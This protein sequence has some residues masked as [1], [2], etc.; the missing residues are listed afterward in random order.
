MNL[1]NVYNLEFVCFEN[2]L[3]L[4]LPCLFCHWMETLL[5]PTPP[6]RLPPSGGISSPR[7]PFPSVPLCGYSSPH[8]RSP[9]G[10]PWGCPPS[11][12]GLSCLPREGM[13]TCS[14]PANGFRMNCLRNK[15]KKNW[16]RREEKEEV[17]EETR[18]SY[19]LV[20]SQSCFLHKVFLLRI[21]I[22]HSCS[23]L[24]L[25]LPLPLPFEILVIFQHRGQVSFCG[26][27]SDHTHTYT[28]TH[29]LHSLTLTHT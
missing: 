4:P 28:L 8:A 16:K 21:M 3:L 23:F 9:D 13:P 18:R 27:F 5:A 11:R 20:C 29:T 19:F 15:V 10:T 22:F 26:D 12:P 14:A 7:F 25:E 2:H 6:A 24:Y 1:I 17:K